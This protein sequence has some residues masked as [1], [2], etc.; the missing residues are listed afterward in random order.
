M[1]RRIVLAVAVSTI[2]VLGVNAAPASATAD[3]D[4]VVAQETAPTGG[5]CLV[6]QQVCEGEG[7]GFIESKPPLDPKDDPP[8]QMTRSLIMIG[9]LA[10]VFFLYVGWAFQRGTTPSA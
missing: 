3:A 10:L 8:G 4:R 6:G 9:L 2:A 7:G 1:I 5:D